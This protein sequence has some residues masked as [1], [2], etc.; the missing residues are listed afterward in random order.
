MV[1]L[2]QEGDPMSGVQP[3]PNICKYYEQ[4][5]IICNEDYLN[6]VY[7]VCPE[8][9]EIVVHTPYCLR[10][11]APLRDAKSPHEAS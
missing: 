5:S 4:D 6:C 7:V 2:A 11:K 10:C 9:G 8:C 3:C 1:E